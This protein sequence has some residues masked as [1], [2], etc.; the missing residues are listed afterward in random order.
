MRQWERQS[1]K[2][3]DLKE[4]LKKSEQNGRKLESERESAENSLRELQAARE[5]LRNQAK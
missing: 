2:M 4:Q 3:I 5:K 1:S